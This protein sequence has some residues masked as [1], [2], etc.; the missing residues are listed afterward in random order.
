MRC[1]FR[2]LV[3]PTIGCKVFFLEDVL[4]DSLLHAGCGIFTII[5][6]N[7]YAF[8]FQQNAPSSD[9]LAIS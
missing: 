2:T 6:V 5:V 7:I 3:I 1:L 8:L 4:L 9:T